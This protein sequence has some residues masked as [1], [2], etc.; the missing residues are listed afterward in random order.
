M[1]IPIIDCHTHIFPKEIRE[2]RENYLVD[3]PA[4]NILYHSPKSKLCGAAELIQMMDEQEIQTSIVL[5]FPWKKKDTFQRH[6][7]YLLESVMKYKGRLI[8]LCCFDLWNPHA[9]D[10]L[11]RCLQAGLSGAGELAF[12]DDSFDQ[13]AQS[14]LPQIM[15]IC[16]EKNVPMMLHTNEPVGHA[17]HGKT[18][19]QLPHL[20]KLIQ[21]FKQNTIILAHWGG[22]IFFYNLM[23]RDVKETLSNVYLDTAASPYLYDP[24]IYACAIQVFGSQKILFGSDYPLI[25]PKRYVQEMEQ[26]NLSQQDF[27]AICSDNARKLFNQ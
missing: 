19:M 8:G 24:S 11:E 22:G 12:Y 5:G 17:Y 4:F 18:N 16:R 15:D 20:Y 6:N 9:A 21:Q 27:I 13:Y 7:D 10:E 14:M 1:T 2:S 25:K 23:K 26:A 3:E